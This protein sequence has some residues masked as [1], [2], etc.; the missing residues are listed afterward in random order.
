MH[1]IRCALFQAVKAGKEVEYVGLTNYEWLLL[2]KE[3]RAVN[4]ANKGCQLIHTTNGYS[5][6]ELFNTEIRVKGA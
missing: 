2:K 1:E 4:H 5:K 6:C 3:L